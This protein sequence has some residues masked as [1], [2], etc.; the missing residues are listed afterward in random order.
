MSILAGCGAVVLDYPAGRAAL[1]CFKGV[2]EVLLMR[3]LL[4]RCAQ[5]QG[6]Q[7]LC[8]SVSAPVWESP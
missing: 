2:G 7:D 3:I 6:R 4:D 5:A 1:D 8:S